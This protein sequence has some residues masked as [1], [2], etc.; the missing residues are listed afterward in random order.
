ML[1]QMV[2]FLEETFHARLSD[3]SLEPDDLRSISGVIALMERLS[4]GEPA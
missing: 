1:L 3:E 2:S 4:S